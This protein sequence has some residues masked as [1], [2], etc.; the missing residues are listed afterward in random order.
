M[1]TL[2]LTILCWST[3]LLLALAE[4]P[5]FRFDSEGCFTMMQVT[6]IQDT[7]KLALRTI[8][9][10]D[11]AI[12][13]HHPG[14]IVLTGDNTASFNQKGGFELAAAAFVDVFTTNNTPFA[15]TFGN[16]DSEKEGPDLYTREEQYAIYKNLGGE[17][18]VDHDLPA[19]S[20]TG[21]G[22]IPILD[23]A[24]THSLFNLFLMDSGAYATGG[25]DGVKSDQIQWYEESSGTTPCL[26]FQHI[27]VPDIFTSGLLLPVPTNTPACVF[28]KKGEY[29]DRGYLLN[30][31]L[32][33]GL[34]KE[35]PCPTARGPYND[36]AH[37]Y[38]GRTLYQSWCKM[39]NLKGAYFGHDHKN[40]FDGTDKNGIRLGYT[41]AATLHS[42]NDNDPGG[43]IFWIKKDGTFT[44]ATVSE[45]SLTKP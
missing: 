19:L 5:T 15:V 13:Q 43:R 27:I 25:Y 4:K 3:S 7:D 36:A 39:K 22:V 32:A 31:E 1:R 38:E 41:K 10:L 26:W 23:T 45:A 20:G 21:S 40:T 14:V 12:K 6:D 9:F 30:T 44:T 24:G 8:A 42:Y 18:F 35:V 11:N 34:L 29:S 37:T 16:H 28:H 2:L 17:L 33:K